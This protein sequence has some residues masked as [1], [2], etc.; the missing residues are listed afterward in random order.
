MK[1]LTCPVILTGAATRSDG[2][3]SLRFSTPELSPDEKV[4]FMEI[5]NTNLKLLLQPVD[6]E[7]A[8]LKEVKGQFDT[9]TPSQ[10]LRAVLYILWKQADGTG[11]FEDFYKRRIEDIINSVKRKLEAKT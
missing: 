11:E 1:A 6:N 8:E 10:R 9:K 2:S 7:P 3:L 4:A 5:Q